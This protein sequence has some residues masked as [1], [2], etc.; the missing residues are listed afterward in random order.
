MIYLFRHGAV[1]TDGRRFIGQS[2]RPLN[3]EGRRQA[4]AWRDRLEG[5]AWRAVYAGDLDRTRETA[6]IIAGKPPTLLPELREIH[7][8]DWEGVPMAEIR[9][10]QPERWRER[11]ERMDQ[12]RPL[13]GESF[14]DLQKRVWPVFQT[15][16]EGPGPALVVAHAGV[17]RAILCRLL[18]MPLAALFRL[19]QDPGCLNRIDPTRNPFRVVSVNEPAVPGEAE[20]GLG[21]RGEK[22][23]GRRP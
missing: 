6:E 16:A 1:D 20:A 15:L 5:M 21:V 2:N 10:T 12:F 9:R 22:K 18:A 11:G 13:G 8:G 4:G 3:A 17:N 19:G 23:G 7:L 14:A